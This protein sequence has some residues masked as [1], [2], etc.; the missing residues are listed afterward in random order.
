MVKFVKRISLLQQSFSG[1]KNNNLDVTKLETFQVDCPFLSFKIS[2]NDM[3][4]DFS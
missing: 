1:K 4:S 3:I 2:F